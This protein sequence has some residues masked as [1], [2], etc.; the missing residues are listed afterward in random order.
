VRLAAD[1]IELSR[2]KRV[3]YQVLALGTRARALN[4]LGR[5]KEA[6]ADLRRAVQLAR[7]L[8]D[9]ALFPRVAAALLALDG[10]EGLGA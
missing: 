3:E 7:P 5:G 2:G 4:R 1:A 6:V 9:P 8:G 10:D